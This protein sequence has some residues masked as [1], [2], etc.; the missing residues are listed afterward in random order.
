MTSLLAHA[1]TVVEHIDLERDVWTSTSPSREALDAAIYRLRRR[2]TR[3]GTS[4]TT[5]RGRGF[6]LVLR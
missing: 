3:V 5:I 2:L 1:G 4:I 6:A